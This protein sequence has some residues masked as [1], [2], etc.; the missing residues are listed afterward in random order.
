MVPEH[1]KDV[2]EW[3]SCVN[4]NKLILNY[5]HDVKVGDN[6]NASGLMTQ[7]T[8]EGGDIHVGSCNHGSESIRSNSDVTGK[9]KG[10][11]KANTLFFFHC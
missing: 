7:L 1:D 8:L 10:I 6:K 2:L 4:Q 5:L 3:A 11:F 9:V